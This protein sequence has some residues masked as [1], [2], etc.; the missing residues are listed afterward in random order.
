[1]L[2]DGLSKE[3]REGITAKYIDKEVVRQD[4]QYL[5]YMI[6]AAQAN[7]TVACTILPISRKE[8]ATQQAQEV[9]EEC[10]QDAAQRGGN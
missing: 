10:A 7:E 8:Y 9:A 6:D 4:V 2:F 5:Q 3:Q 1:M